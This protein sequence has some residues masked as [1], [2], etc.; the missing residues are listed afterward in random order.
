MIVRVLGVAAIA[1]IYAYS[2]I[3]ADDYPIDQFERVT[4]C[5][6]DPSCTVNIEDRITGPVGEAE[7]LSYQYPLCVGGC[8]MV[9]TK[10]ACWCEDDEKCG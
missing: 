9:C 4:Q 5:M 7:D 2:A 10:D 3:A 8:V 6:S 1:L